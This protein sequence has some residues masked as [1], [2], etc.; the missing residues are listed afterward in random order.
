MSVFYSPADM[1]A[2]S[3]ARLI[4]DG[5]VA[6]AASTDPAV[7]GVRRFN[8]AAAADARVSLTTIQTVGAKG[9]DGFALALV[10]GDPAG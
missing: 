9:Y 8:E 7:Q 3:M 5:E 4:R 10:L 1:M 6:D 2:V